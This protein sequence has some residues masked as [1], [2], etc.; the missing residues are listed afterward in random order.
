MNVGTHR[1]HC[2]IRHGCKYGNED[3]PVALG[4]EPMSYLQCQLGAEMNRTCRSLED[5]T[6]WKEKDA[7]T[8]NKNSAVPMSN[9]VTPDELR[10][11]A[12]LSTTLMDIHDRCKDISFDDIVIHDSNGE[13]LGFLRYG[14]GLFGF[15]SGMPVP[16]EEI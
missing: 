1:E 13:V 14:D 16:E 15:H 11:I 9:Y 2:C 3:C 6:K 5:V 10:Q 8:Q 12:D 7:M 4:E